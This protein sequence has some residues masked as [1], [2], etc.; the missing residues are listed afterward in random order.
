MVDPCDT[1][2]VTPIETVQWIKDESGNPVGIAVVYRVQRENEI[3]IF[4]LPQAENG[5]L[6]RVRI[7]NGHEGQVRSLSV[8][9]DG[10]FMVSSGSD[11][12]VCTWPLAGIREAINAEGNLGAQ[13][14][15]SDVDDNSEA[16]AESIKVA[17]S[18]KWG[19]SWTVEDGKLMLARLAPAAPLFEFGLRSGDEIIQLNWFS[20]ADDGSTAIAHP[21]NPGDEAIRFLESNDFDT[22]V[23]FSYLRAGS[24]VRHVQLKPHW[25]PLIS[26][27]FSHGRE[28][29]A[30][31]AAGYYTSSFNGNTLFGWQ[32]NRGVQNPPDFY[33]ADRFQALLERPE[34]LKRVLTAGSVEQAARA[35]GERIGS[36]FH[37][38]EN[39]VALQPQVRLL[40][41]QPGFDSGGSSELI[42][43]AEIVLPRGSEITTLKAFAN[44]VPAV[45]S[46]S[47]QQSD[48]AGAEGQVKT[49]AT[50]RAGLPSDSTIKV[51]V[52]VANQERLVGT[53]EVL[54]RR[55]EVPSQLRRPRLWV[56]AGG[57][58][59][60]NDDRIAPLKTPEQNV[61]SFIQWIERASGDVYDC[62]VPLALTGP[63][64]TRNNWLA[65]VHDKLS[66]LQSTVRPDDVVIVF[67]SGHG[68]QDP[69][70]QD[71]FFVTA[72]ANYSHVRAGDFAHC[73]GVSEIAPFA[74]LACRK[75]VILDTCHSGALQ[76]LES[77]RLKSAVR[78]LQADLVLTLT[79][80]EGD[81]AAAEVVGHSHSLFTEVLGG[82]LSAPL[83]TNAD[84]L[85]TWPELVQQVRDGVLAQS[86]AMNVA[87]MP[88]VVPAELLPY[89]QLPLTLITA[90]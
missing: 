64:M 50:W 40:R 87:Q 72:N 24:D 68:L 27:T 34:V 67:L 73:L 77:D 4:A 38:L 30:W 48:V 51:Q 23:K 47:V 16:S 18:R 70:T 17:S 79:A 84:R 75:V 42:V 28:W 33:R 46:S 19:A 10:Q 35:V 1:R 36:N 15:L 41:P 45:L 32:V 65:I 69:E 82:A 54:V 25:R 39:S 6:R 76:P 88:T 66:E 9:A 90:P 29:A 31:T 83:D 22:I 59:H 13:P 21:I 86:T 89:I 11:R 85:Y 74:D 58:G 57:V 12:L 80:S 3:H 5:R 37:P 44:G 78:L 8:S 81:A 43:E 55:A 52:A 49:I 7:F 56:F 61:N 60:Y 20:L 62:Q 53:D 26:Q 14:T 2:V 71:Y 63:E